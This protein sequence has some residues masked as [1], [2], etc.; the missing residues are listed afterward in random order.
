IG[1]TGGGSAVES[2]G[3][4]TF[5]GTVLA[6]IQSNDLFDPT[7]KTVTWTINSIASGSSDGVLVGYSK[8]GELVPGI[9][10][11][12]RRDRMGFIVQPG[13]GK[14]YFQF[15]LGDTDPNEMYI[16]DFN[17]PLVASFT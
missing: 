6:S 5:G 4:V 10:I 2:G 1:I 12:L 15:M 17:S 9:L 3:N 7:G 16:W 11:E 13:A 8:P 14:T